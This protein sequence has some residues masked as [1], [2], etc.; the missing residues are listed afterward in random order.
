MGASSSTSVLGRSSTAYDVLRHYD[1]KLSGKTALV[2]GAASGIGL[3]TVKALTSVG[4]KVLATARDPIEGLRI[5]KAELAGGPSC[6]TPYAGDV[7]LVRLL[8]LELERLSSVRE[9][10]TAVGSAAPEGLD[11]VILNAGIM[12]LPNRE[13]TPAGFEKQIG[14]NH[15]GHH[16]LVSLLRPALVARPSKPCRIVYLS[17]LAHQMGNVDIK[18]LHFAQGRVYKPWV[19]YG[20]SKK[21]NMLEARELADQLK[22]EAPHITVASLHPGVIKTKLARHMKLLDN[23]LVV[24]VFSC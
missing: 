7:S 14:V 2:T 5:I 3:E 22:V 8:P 19:A 24:R 12:A 9:L 13:T 21:A 6:N 15:F 1:A 20:Q 11:L 17:S 16:L 10:A 23:F 4:C 18:D